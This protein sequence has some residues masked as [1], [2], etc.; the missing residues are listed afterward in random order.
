[1]RRLISGLNVIFFLY[2]PFSRRVNKAFIGGN[3]LQLI[4]MG[5][6]KNKY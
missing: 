2:I 1:M 3:I 4:D 5:Y 6:I